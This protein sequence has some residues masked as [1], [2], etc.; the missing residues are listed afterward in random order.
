MSCRWFVS[1]KIIITFDKFAFHKFRSSLSKSSFSV[2]ISDMILWIWFVERTALS[3]LSVFSWWCLNCSK[4]FIVKGDQVLLFLVLSTMFHLPLSVSICIIISTLTTGILGYVSH[5]KQLDNLYVRFALLSHHRT[6]TMHKYIQV[7]VSPD[8]F[9]LI[10]LLFIL[11]KVNKYPHFKY[12]LQC[13]T[14]HH[15]LSPLSSLFFF[16]VVSN[17]FAN[18][19]LL[20]F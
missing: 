3:I 17:I 12:Y 4:K 16:S 2:V 18:G 11:W 15:H 20:I 14:S 1:Q 13:F 10:L 5:N 19:Y 9:C 7:C 6:H 8:D